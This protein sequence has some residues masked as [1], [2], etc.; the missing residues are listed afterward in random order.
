MTEPRHCARS[1]C[2][3]FLRADA[4]PN[5]KHCSDRCRQLAADAAKLA[6]NTAT[7]SV[8]GAPV[9]RGSKFCAK[10]RP[11][12]TA[13]ALDAPPTAIAARLTELRAA[14]RL[15][16]PA[17][18]QQIGV[19]QSELWRLEHHRRSRIKRDIANRLAG[20][21]G[22]KNAAWYREWAIKSLDDYQAQQAKG[23]ALGQASKGKP[24]TPEHVERIQRSLHR[25]MVKVYGPRWRTVR[26]KMAGAVSHT[27][28]GQPGKPRTEQ[29]KAAAR[30]RS[31]DS[32]YFVAIGAIGR[33]R[34]GGKGNV[35]DL[36]L[37]EDQVRASTDATKAVRKEIMQL[38][39]RHPT[40]TLDEIRTSLAQGLSAKQLADRLALDVRRAQQLAALVRAVDNREIPRAQ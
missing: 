33:L 5:R 35:T 1:G 22:T 19:T 16:A 25:T 24:K 4:R 2:P 32:L 21:D 38:P 30:K 26:A 7:C 9:S 27:R 34:R 28:K 13:R 39:G 8:C 23:R 3:N 31:P 36:L 18:A 37:L 14:R 6:R 11:G 20:W 17:A 12:R 10:H 40:Y 15:T 29:Q